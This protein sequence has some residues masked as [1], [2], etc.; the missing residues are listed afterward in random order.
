VTNPVYERRMGER[1]GTWHATPP[2]IDGL[3]ERGI[4][5]EEEVKAWK[6]RCSLA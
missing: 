6:D 2:W 3:T 5:D 4:A 1:L